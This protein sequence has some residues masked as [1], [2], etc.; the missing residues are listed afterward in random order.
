MKRKLSGVAAAVLLA[1]S[2]VTP[3]AAAEKSVGSIE[4]GVTA[5]TAGEKGTAAP[6]VTCSTEGAQVV[7][8]QWTEPGDVLTPFEGVFAE[9]TEYGV[10]V[11]IKINEEYG[12][13]DS[14][15][16][17]TVNGEP[18]SANIKP[19]EIS[20]MHSLVAVKGGASTSDS[21]ADSTADSGK[22]YDNSNN[23]NGAIPTNEGNGTF[24][25]FGVVIGIIAAAGVAYFIY[26]KRK[27]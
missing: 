18:A 21:T 17:V 6:K 11:N 3:A 13:S 26:T 7:S 22:S 24:I 2:A 4:L 23:A 27:K 1:L 12:I 5:P 10:T 25:I 15:F 19:G 8:A 16:K 9:G 20:V 14:D